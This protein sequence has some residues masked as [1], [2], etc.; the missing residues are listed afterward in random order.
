MSQST[1]R[2]INTGA[3]RTAGTPSTVEPQSHEKPTR[4]QSAPSSS[5]LHDDESSSFDAYRKSVAER[6]SIAERRR[7]DAE[8]IIIST[9]SFDQL[10]AA[11]LAATVA[12]FTGASVP[13]LK[14]DP[15]ET[16]AFYLARASQ[17]FANASG[18]QINLP[19]M[20]PDPATFSPS[21][22]AL[23]VN[24]L[25]FLSLALSLS[26]ILL[27]SSLQR[28]ALRYGCAE[29]DSADQGDEL[30][31]T[32]L[33]RILPVVLR[34][35]I[36]F[37]Y[38]GLAMLLFDSLKTYLGTWQALFLTSTSILGPVLSRLLRG[39]VKWVIGRLDWILVL[40]ELRDERGPVATEREGDSK[41]PEARAQAC[42]EST[43]GEEGTLGEGGDSWGRGTWGAGAGRW[44]T[45]GRAP[46]GAALL[47]WL[48]IHAG[49]L[50]GIVCIAPT[51]GV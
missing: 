9:Y 18:V 46:Q 16:S 43:D 34:I 48:G 45:R 29:P 17:L 2:R 15:R 47:W 19:F 4:S 6:M 28:W 5:A 44:C 35:S 40:R 36:S 3:I 13:G 1:Q 24:S 20:P 37:F 26:V 11:L 25:W 30:R 7:A 8:D 12:V 50:R 21:R 41:A 22:S 31:V 14:P 23:W 33:S 27:A 10:Q 38:V 39:V 32:W 51:G 49:G 42:V